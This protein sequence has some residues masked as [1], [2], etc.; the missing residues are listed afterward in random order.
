MSNTNSQ[1]DNTYSEQR[2]INIEQLELQYNEIL[3]SYLNN[4]E[5]YLKNKSELINDDQTL[6][7]EYRLKVLQDNYKLLT[8]IRTI[9]KDIVNTEQRRSDKKIDNSNKRSLILKNK[10]LLE[11]QRK[12]LLEDKDDLLTKEARINQLET[13]Y[14]GKYK[15]YTGIL[16]TDIVI[17][18]LL[19]LML[20]FSF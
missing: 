20:I 3:N 9:H 5:N 7:K 15:T 11:K 19:L 13:L 18:V 8:I 1:R 14:R 12:L 2:I 10:K 16:I 6:A 17:G 4:Y